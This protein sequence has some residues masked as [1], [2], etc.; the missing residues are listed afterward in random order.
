MNPRL[1]VWDGVETLDTCESLA[2]KCRPFVLV[3]G[4]FPSPSD[5]IIRQEGSNVNTFLK[6]NKKKV[7][8]KNLLTD[9]PSCAIIVSVDEGHE[10]ST[11]GDHHY[12][13]HHDHH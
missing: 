9:Q 13:A 12:E 2:T 6:K 7:F 4:V 8:F 3:V 10:P 1:A 11:K 5:S